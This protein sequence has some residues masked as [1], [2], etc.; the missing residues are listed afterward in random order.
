VMETAE[1][2]I[3]LPPLAGHVV[4]DNLGGA[5]GDGVGMRRAER[6]LLSFNRE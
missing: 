6:N 2:A 3:L 5:G 1:N 4:D